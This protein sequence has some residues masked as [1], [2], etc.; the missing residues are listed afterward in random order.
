MLRP[1]TGGWSLLLALCITTMEVVTSIIVGLLLLA[2]DVELNPGPGK[3][4]RMT[5]SVDQQLLCCE[6]GLMMNN[7]SLTVAK[8]YL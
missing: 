2:G 8:Q 6:C 1:S 5:L 4:K 3:G 7:L